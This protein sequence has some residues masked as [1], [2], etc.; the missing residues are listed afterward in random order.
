MPNHYAGEII[1]IA[2]HSR[3]FHQWLSTNNSILVSEDWANGRLFQ[4]FELLILLPLRQKEVAL[5]ASLP[6]LL[7]LLHSSSTICHSV[8]SYFE[9]EEGKRV[10]IIADGWDELG[11]SERLEG[12]FMYNFLFQMFPFMSVI[13]TSRSSASAPLHRLP[14]IDRFVEVCGFSE[15]NIKE[16]ILS[17]FISD[18]KKAIHLIEQL[19]SNPLVESVCSIP[20]NCAIVC[21]LW[22]THE[23]ILP[24]TM[25]EL[26]TKIIL[27][28]I[29]HNIQKHHAY[30]NILSLLSFNALPEGLQ[31]SWWL[32]CDFAFQTIEKDRIVFHQEELVNFFPQGLALDE[33]VLCFGLLQRT[34]SIFEVGRGVSF[35]FLH[36]TFQEYLA[37]LHL[38]RQITQDPNPPTMEEYTFRSF[39]ESRRFAVVWRF[40]FGI[41]F[42]LF[43]CS[44]C[45][46]IL[47]YVPYSDDRLL[48]CHCAFEA[49]NVDIDI[50]VVHL[51][52]EGYPYLTFSYP[53]TAHDCAA[54]CHYQ[55]GRV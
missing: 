18:Q 54:I 2:Y 50:E 44:D 15:E 31:Q 26:Y 35:H 17:E 36:L 10:V 12:S 25:T 22:R 28:V 4:Q 42:N 5:A 27:N 19:E 51:L 38:A 34:E 1:N 24:T 32:L 9:E 46:G 47:P 55:Y 52:K 49:K 45:L 7:K 48:L 39:D 6:E 43:R 13:L 30:K 3:N 29:L 20:L 33:N 14:Y 8:A 21:H 11:E 37:A 16:Y 41:Y 53:S 40:L 23:E